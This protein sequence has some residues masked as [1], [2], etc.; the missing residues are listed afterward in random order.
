MTTA[1]RSELRPL[2]SN[3][4]AAI[5]ECEQDPQA[6]ALSSVWDALKAFPGNDL[7]Q[8]VFESLDKAATLVSAAITCTERG[9]EVDVLVSLAVMQNEGPQEKPEEEPTVAAVIALTGLCHA[10]FEELS[11]FDMAKRAWERAY[12]KGVAALG[13]LM[14]DLPDAPDIDLTRIC[15]AVDAFLADVNRAIGYRPLFE[16]RKA[17]VEAADSA[18]LFP[19][20]GRQP[21]WG[22]EGRG[23]RRRIGGAEYRFEV[24]DARPL[25]K[26][27]GGLI[28]VTRIDLET[29]QESPC[30][31]LPRR[32]EYGPHRAAEDAVLERI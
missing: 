16:A 4:S 21:A 23:W 10:R 12:R 13:V 7:D 8:D 19:V 14:R 2:I 5:R 22:L 11:Y 3:A 24:T 28:V 29:G 9:H 1:I 20:G 6:G 15:H 27:P 32:F 31:V 17:L 26:A 25:E 30:H 18:L